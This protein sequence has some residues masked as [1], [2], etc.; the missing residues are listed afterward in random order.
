MKIQVLITSL[1]LSLFLGSFTQAQ[2]TEKTP[3]KRDSIRAAKWKKKHPVQIDTVD[4]KVIKYVDVT[5]GAHDGIIMGNEAS[6]ER[7]EKEHRLYVSNKKTFFKTLIERVNK[8][9]EDNKIT[10]EKAEEVKANFAQE[11]AEIIMAHRAKTDAEINLLKINR[12]SAFYDYRLEDDDTSSLQISTKTG[13]NVNIKNHR[14]QQKEIFTT[15]GYTIGFGYNYMNGDELGINDFSYPNNNYFSLGYQWKTRLDAKNNFRL[16]YGVEYQSQGTE[17]N[18]NRFISQG[19]QAQI[20]D[21]GFN[22]EKAK[23]RQDQL[24][25]PL[26]L[27]FGGSKR[28][29][30]ED[31]RIRF[32]EY[33]EWNF[34]IGGFAGFN[35]SSRLKL[36]YDLDGREIKE[37]RIDDFDNEVL[38][39]GIDAYIGHG[40]FTFFGRMNLNNVFKNNSVDAQYVTFG[41]RIQ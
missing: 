16:L 13:I 7:L 20:A 41:I 15:S 32:Q 4:G 5:P 18:G 21:I 11:L 12:T 25:F 3:T 19:D 35:M 39:Y 34:G 8:S 1:V 37:T 9:V 22:V 2:E 27:E 6:I 14:E 24:V 36:K 31:G 26:H 29:E 38:V 33:D 17:L 10:E 28:K 40:D 23:F 30:Y